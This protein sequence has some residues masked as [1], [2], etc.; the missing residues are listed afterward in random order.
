MFSW[1]LLYKKPPRCSGL[2][3]QPVGCDGGWVQE[4]WMAEPPACGHILKQMGW[5][6]SCG[7]WTGLYEQVQ[8]PV[9]LARAFNWY[10]ASSSTCIGP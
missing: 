9:V 8:A 2:K 6:C 4:G 10:D 7:A 3:Q 1:I 5:A